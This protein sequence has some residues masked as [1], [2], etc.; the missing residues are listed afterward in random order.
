MIGERRLLGLL[1]GQRL[2]G[3]R[4]RRPDRAAQG[5]RSARA[6]RRAAPG[7]PRRE[8]AAGDPRHVPAR[9]ALPD[10]RGD[11]LRRTRSGSS[12]LGERQFV[13]VFPRRDEFERF[14]SFLVYLPRE[15]FHTENRLKI[16]EILRA[17]PSSGTGTDFDLRLTESVLVRLHIVIATQP[18]RRPGVRRLGDR[19][20]D[21]GGDPQLDR[22][23]APRAARGA[24]AAAAPTTGGAT[25]TAFPVVYRADNPVAQAVP[26][27]PLDRRPVPHRRRWT[28]GCTGAVDGLRCRVLTWKAALE[29]SDIVPILEHMGVRVADERPYEI[30]PVDAPVTHISDFGLR[31]DAEVEIGD[32]V[33]AGLRGR[34]VARADRP[35]GQRSASTGSS[36]ARACSGA[37]RSCC[38]P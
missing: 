8:G 10:R 32:D 9:R 38:G 5:A 16:Q 25:P 23:P 33:R 36:S 3:R 35:A 29:L 27:H 6:A 4:H 31:R 26:R 13:R 22:R 15:R 24:R 18:G 17:A 34:P 20:A 19:G 7:R 37:T 12:A 1:T 28:C 11:A 21:L 14:V 30:T 2:Q